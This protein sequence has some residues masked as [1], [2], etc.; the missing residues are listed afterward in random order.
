MQ[1]KLAF[2]NIII[3]YLIFFAYVS[4]IG[5]FRYNKILETASIKVWNYILLRLPT[6]F[7]F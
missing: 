5:Y 2:L 1:L 4:T 3:L 6:I 7:Q